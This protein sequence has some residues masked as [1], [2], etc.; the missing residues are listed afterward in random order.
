MTKKLKPEQERWNRPPLPFPIYRRQTEV[1]VYMGAGWVK[2]LVTKS[3]KN[4]CQAYLPQLR[5]EVIVHDARNIYELPK[6]EK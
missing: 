1:R 5:R 4:W 6:S 2:G 3:N